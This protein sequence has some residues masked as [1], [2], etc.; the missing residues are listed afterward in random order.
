[1]QLSNRVAFVT[2]AG[3]GIGRAGA[4]AMAVQGARVV[5]SDLDGQAARAV[6]DAILAAGG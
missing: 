5:V 2:G 1:M 3:S 6:A 4:F